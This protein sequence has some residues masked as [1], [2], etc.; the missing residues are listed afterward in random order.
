MKKLK[1]IV[2]LL[3]CAIVPFGLVACDKTDEEQGAGNIQISYWNSGWGDEW[4]F[5][6]A[7]SFMENNPGYTV[8]I[9]SSVA[10]GKISDLLPIPDENPYDLIM[11]V[12]T[13]SALRA[14]YY[15]P[16]DDVLT[17]INEGETKTIGEKMGEAIT[18]VLVDSDGHYKSLFFGSGFYTIVYNVEIFEK[19][20]IEEPKTTDELKGTVELLKGYGVA[21]FIHFSGGGY[22]HALFWTWAMQY[23]NYNDFYKIT[24]NPSLEKMTDDENGIKQA[25]QVVYEIIGDDDNYHQGSTGMDF[26]TCQSTFLAPSSRTGKE[27][28]MMINGSWMQNE[29]K[30]S[31]EEITTNVRS[32]KTPIVSSIINKCTT[33]K[34]DQTLSKVISAID[35][36]KTSFSG[37]SQADFDLIKKA[38]TVE[39]TNTTALECMVPNYSD[40]IDGAKKFLTYFY[41]DQALKEFADSTHVL[42]LVSFDDETIKIDNSNYSTFEKSQYDIALKS[43]PIVEGMTQKKHEIFSDGGLSLLGGYKGGAYV[44]AL[45]GINGSSS[46]KVKNSEELWEKIKVSVTELWPTSWAN[47][48]LTPPEN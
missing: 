12:N 16:L 42:S 5:K 18:S 47:I 28:A 6:I 40:C 13:K 31:E 36:G 41:S 25:L 3:L 11:G 24:E 35:K 7:E 10:D 39:I 32:M 14:E 48:G 34:D 2:A 27:I 20:D 9:D 17:A 30:N 26:T 38:R 19:Y 46:A 15:E 44:T 29:M 45:E 33:I 37:I 23:N 1:R 21:P 43:K 22:L 8:E 4:L